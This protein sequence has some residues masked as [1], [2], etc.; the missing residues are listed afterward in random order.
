MNNHW[1][2]GRIVTSVCSVTFCTCGLAF[3]DMSDAKDSMEQRTDKADQKWRD[4]RTE[5][6]PP[7][8]TN[9]EW[10]EMNIGGER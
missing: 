3:A 4:H 5:Y 6:D 9:R 10:G 2:A 1:I 7:Q 8:L